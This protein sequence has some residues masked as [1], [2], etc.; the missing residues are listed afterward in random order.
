MLGKWCF[1]GQ[2]M[3]AEHVL[4]ANALKGL[5]GNRRVAGGSV[6]SS[7]EESLPSPPQTPPPHPSTSP[8]GELSISC[9]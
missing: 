7:R 1:Y 8:S 6:S 3:F 4:S 5:S 9:P 2:Q